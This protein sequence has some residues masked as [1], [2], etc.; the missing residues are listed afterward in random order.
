MIFSKLLNDFPNIVKPPCANQTVKHNEVHYID[1]FGPPVFVLKP[2]RMAPDSVKN[3]E[4]GISAH[5]GFSHM[6]PSSSNYS[7]PLHMVPK[8]SNDWR[9]VG[10]F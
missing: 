10:D 8:E 3:C 1:T 9:P 4:N 6:R 2:R 7:S 5:V